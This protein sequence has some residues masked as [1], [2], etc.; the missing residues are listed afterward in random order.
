MTPNPD[1]VASCRQQASAAADRFRLPLR[2]Q[3]WQGAAG[4]FAGAGTGSSLDFQDHRQYSP[5]D[6]PR[7]INWQAYA[8]TGQYSMKL[9][10]E[11][12]R[13]LVDLIFEVSPS[14]FYEPE[15]ERRSVELFLFLAESAIRSGA[16]LRTLLLCGGQ[17]HLLSNDSLTSQHWLTPIE[18]LQGDQPQVTPDTSRL[19]LRPGSLR[20]FLSDLLYPG[21]PIQILRPLVQSRGLP[22]L[23]APYSTS[24]ADPDWDGNLEL[25]DS[26]TRTHHPHRINPSILKKYHQQYTRH[27][28]LW[29]QATTRHHAPLAR[30]ASR[31]PLPTA[32]R[33]GALTAK[34]LQINA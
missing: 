24:E 23:F 3:T 18:G 1:I 8:R 33:Q 29:K 5:G 14:M 30:I 20:I 2:S 9:Y 17:H 15:K 13:P 21:D 25:I 11:E 34:A 22:I 31:L 26:E 16:S 28:S 12:V 32:L 7:H 19:P 6:D 4:E 27:F 10:R